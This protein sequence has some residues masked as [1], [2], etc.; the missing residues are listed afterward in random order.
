W[1]DLSTGAGVTT[2]PANDAHSEAPPPGAHRREQQPRPADQ[3]PYLADSAD[4]SSDSRGEPRPGEPRQSQL[5]GENWRNAGRGRAEFPAFLPALSR[6]PSPA[7][8]A[9]PEPDRSQLFCGNRRR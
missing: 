1:P 9:A 5:P 2:V 4:V 6:L 7:A 8:N 3:W